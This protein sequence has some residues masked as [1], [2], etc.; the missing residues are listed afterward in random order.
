[1]KKKKFA[2]MVVSLSMPRL[3]ASCTRPWSG[4][5]ASVSQSVSFGIVLLEGA[6][7]ALFLMSKVPLYSGPRLGFGDFP[8]FDRMGGRIVR[9]VVPLE[10]T[11][12]C[13]VY[14][15]SCITQAV[16]HE[17]RQ[18]DIQTAS[19]SVNQSVSQIDVSPL[20]SQSVSQSVSQ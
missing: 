12:D 8:E 4:P 11:P 2:R 20:V 17:D 3:T 19:S 1:M 16:T 7:G 10:S 18:T 9:L 13:F 15:D 6:K 14:E 5:A